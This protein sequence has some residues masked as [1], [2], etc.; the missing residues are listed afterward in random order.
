MFCPSQSLK[1]DFAQILKLSCPLPNKNCNNNVEY[2]NTTTQ[3][4]TH[5]VLSP[6]SNALEGKTL[7]CVLPEC[8]IHLQKN[9]TK[10]IIHRLLH[11]QCINRMFNARDDVIVVSNNTTTTVSL[12]ILG[13]LVSQPR[14]Q[15]YH[16]KALA[17]KQVSTNRNYSPS[18][19]LRSMISLSHQDASL[20]LST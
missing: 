8:T 6:K 14:T 9:L 4:P 5:C 11:L 15:S 1:R 20:V 12:T 7:C 2:F 17:R 19:L 18:L 3:Q 13:E 10:P 16:S